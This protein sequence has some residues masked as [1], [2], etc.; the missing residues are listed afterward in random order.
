[1]EFAGLSEAERLNSTKTPVITYISRQE[2]GRRMLRDED[3]KRLV[4][5]LNGL[6]EKY[7]WEV[8]VVSMDKLTRQEQFKLAGRT[9]VRFLIGSMDS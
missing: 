1:M 9:T 7:G 8:N 5:A 2:W 4:A 3:H 6:H